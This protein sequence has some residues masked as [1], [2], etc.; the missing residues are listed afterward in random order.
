MDGMSSN[1]NLK[2]QT[3]IENIW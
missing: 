3:T 1:N 2:L